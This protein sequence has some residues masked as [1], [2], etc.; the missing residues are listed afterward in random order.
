MNDD[1]VAD[2]VE[3]T[4]APET[5]TVDPRLDELIHQLANWRK[6]GV[7]STEHLNE[8][9]KKLEDNKDFQLWTQLHNEAKAKTGSIR[10]EIEKITREIYDQF[11][12]PDTKIPYKYPHPAISIK[13][14]IEP[15]YKEEDAHAWCMDHLPKALK[16]DAAYFEKHARAVLET[17]P[18]E[19]VQFVPKLSVQIKGD[20]AEFVEG[21]K[22]A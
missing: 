22:P 8:L 13:V 3:T 10:V 2:G 18:L 15:Y 21:V 11:L 6:Q 5:I 7:V 16:I 12:Y 1:P 19:F 14:L 20:L 17:A 9:Y 4:Q